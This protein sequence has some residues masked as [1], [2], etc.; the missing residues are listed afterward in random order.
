M[1]AWEI[2]GLRGGVH[3]LQRGMSLPPIPGTTPT[4][5]PMLATRNTRRFVFAPRRDRVRGR[6]L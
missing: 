3:A 5:A 2:I 1:E 6:V 4:G